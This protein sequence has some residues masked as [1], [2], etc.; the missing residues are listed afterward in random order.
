MH[1]L[2][3]N[4]KTKTKLFDELQK[5]FNSETSKMAAK[6]NEV[7]KNFKELKSKT[8]MAAENSA[9]TIQTL[10]MEK[11]NITKLLQAA[12]EKLIT[13][14]NEKMLL[15]SQ[16]NEEG[17]QKNILQKEYLNKCAMLNSISTQLNNEI[18]H[19]NVEISRLSDKVKKLE[20][21]K[22]QIE[23]GKYIVNVP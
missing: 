1:T 16:L 12:E 23:N 10:N 15:I 22:T 21:E 7:E 17:S 5:D 20:A 11:E 2:E 9:L 13:V 6:L 18:V 19:N 14:E 8:N 3:E 4:L